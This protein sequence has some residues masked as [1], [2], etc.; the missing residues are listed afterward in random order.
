[1]NF[2]SHHVVD[3]KQF[4]MLVEIIKATVIESLILY[5]INFVFSVLSINFRNTF[6]IGIMYFREF[7][8]S[9]S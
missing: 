4:L 6:V 2:S 9:V 3:L 5:C 7:L 1:M 8:S